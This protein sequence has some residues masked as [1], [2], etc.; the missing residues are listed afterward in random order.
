[1]IVRERGEWL[2]DSKIIQTTYTLPLLDAFSLMFVFL[3]IFLPN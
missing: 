2:V 3:L 1:M